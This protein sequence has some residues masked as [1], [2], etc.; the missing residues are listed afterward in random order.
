MEAPEPRCLP[1]THW[2]PMDHSRLEATHVVGTQR[3]CPGCVVACLEDD[4]RREK[5]ALRKARPPLLCRIG[6]RLG[7]AIGYQAARVRGVRG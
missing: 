2:G 4:E 7:R 6:A 5:E 3:M 1:R